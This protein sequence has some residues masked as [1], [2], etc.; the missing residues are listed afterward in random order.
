MAGSLRLGG[1]D[2]AFNWKC[3]LVTVV[4]AAGYWLLPPKNKYVLALLV[5]LPYLALAWYDHLYDCRRDPL[6]PTFLYTFYGW[7][8]PAPYRE[9]YRH[10]RPT[11]QRVVLAVDVTLALVLLLFLPKFLRWRPCVRGNVCP[12]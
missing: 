5:F 10:W 7:L 11:T 6:K 2:I 1:D 9:A 8:K 12:C 4:V 3:I